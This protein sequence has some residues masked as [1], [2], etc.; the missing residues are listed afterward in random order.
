M[1]GAAYAGVVDDPR[2]R[3]LSEPGEPWAVEYDLVRREVCSTPATSASWSPAVV[4][5]RR[6]R[7]ADIGA[8]LILHL[9]HHPGASEDDLL[10][11]A[12]AA[13]PDYAPDDYPVD[14]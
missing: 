5:S 2:V 12:R 8:A 4:P 13:R 9:R 11:V 6:R 3:L 7:S 10:E 1:P 14:H